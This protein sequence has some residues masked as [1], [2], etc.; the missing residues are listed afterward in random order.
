[1][2]YKYGDTR[3]L[4]DCI[5]S[6]YENKEQ[7]RKCSVPT[8]E[9]SIKESVERIFQIYQKILENKELGLP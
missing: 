2:L 6:I 3:S 1:M 9:F 8:Q 7:Y 5:R 4:A